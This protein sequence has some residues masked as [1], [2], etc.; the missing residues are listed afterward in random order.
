M[1]HLKKKEDLYKLPNPQQGDLILVGEENSS[2]VFGYTG[3]DWE[4]MQNQKLEF[5]LYE[6]NKTAVAQLPVLTKE[7]LN[8][9]AELFQQMHHRFFNT[10]YMLYGREINYF[11][12]FA[13]NAFAESEEKFSEAVYDCLSNIGPIHSIGETEDGA[14]EFWVA[15]NDNEATCLYLFPYDQGVVPVI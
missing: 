11:T 4:L 1:V 5:N 3:T 10:F 7:Q 9:K 13:K 2:Q 8:E 6:L 14:I 15:I 12:L